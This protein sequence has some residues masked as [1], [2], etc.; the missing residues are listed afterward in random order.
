[1]LICLI[2]CML[3]ATV[4]F[5]DEE[6][7][8]PDSNTNTSDNR[9]NFLDGLQ[10]ATDITAD[11]TNALQTASGFKRI[12]SFIVQ[13]ILYMTV[14]LLG[15]RCALDIMYIAIPFFR[16]ILAN[17]HVG[18]PQIRQPMQGPFGSPMGG[19]FGGMNRFGSPMGYPMGGGYGYGGVS[20]MQAIAP[21]TIAG[22]QLV[23]NAALNAVASEGAV[24]PD[25]KTVNPF[26]IYAKN[27]I[28]TLIATPV[29]I[30]LLVTGVLPQLGFL[31]GDV[32]SDVLNTLGRAIVE[33]FR[34]LGSMM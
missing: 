18:N 20:P 4:A 15:L 33:A 28:V 13:F 3:V 2:L 12:V 30:V 27:M 21:R 32:L 26:K 6:Q 11:T 14:V 19:P 23:S 22:V 7:Q 29:L 10:K 1:M 34:G 9:S 16:G 8:P 17:G 31:I 24:T 25:G 5:A